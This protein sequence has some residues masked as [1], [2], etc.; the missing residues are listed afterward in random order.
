[1]EK[2]HDSMIIEDI[3]KGNVNAYE[4]IVDKYMRKIY[5]YIFNFVKDKHTA[6]DLTQETF[7]KA[8]NSLDKFDKTKN[9]SIWMLS[10]GRNTTWDYFKRIKKYA[11]YEFMEDVDSGNIDND[12]S[13]P[14]RILERKEEINLL[15]DIVNSL[16]SKYKDLIILKYFEELSYSEISSRLKIP[17]NKVKWRLYQARSKIAEQLKEYGILYERGDGCGL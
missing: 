8:Y 15:E 4:K 5:G 6:E 12:F 7:I 11:A 10:I 9:F 17:E 1:M 14:I 3:L 2:N 16:P 13:N